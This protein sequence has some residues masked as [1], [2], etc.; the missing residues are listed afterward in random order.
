M[1]PKTGDAVR[2]G[3]GQESLRR[4][5][6]GWQCRI[7]QIAVRD[8]DG[9]PTPGMRP[10]LAL[11][12]R[13]IGPITVILNKLDEAANTSQLRFLAKKTEDP[14]ERYTAALRYLAATYYQRWESF[15]DQVTA[16]FALADDLPRRLAGRNDCTLSFAQ[17]NQRW[18]LPC[19]AERLDPASDQYQATYWHNALFNPQL[20]GT[21]QIVGFSPDWRL[22]EAS[23]PPPSSRT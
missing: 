21:V 15:S 5:F 14:A 1:S 4:A 19:A 17:F 18:R 11:G 3:E 6:L 13:R 2:Q 16:V 10:E 12:A 22:A 7:R 8:G 23:P 20:P 9:R